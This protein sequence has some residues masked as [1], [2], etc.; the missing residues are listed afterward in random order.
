MGGEATG[1]ASRSLRVVALLPVRNGSLLLPEYLESAAQWCDA[2]IAL[3][4]GSSDRS[5]EMLDEHPLVRLCL[6]MHRRTDYGGWDDQRN[7]QDLLDAANGVGAEWVVYLDVDERI[8]P[9]DALALRGFLTSPDALPGCAYGFQHY[10]MWGR[11][12]D[13]DYCWIYRCFRCEVGQR[14]TSK[15]LHFNPIPTSIDRRAWVRT[16]IRV[17]HFGASSE[18]LRLARLQKYR[19]ADPRHEYGYEFGG[20]ANRPRRIILEWPRRTLGIEVLSDAITRDDH[21]TLNDG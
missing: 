15:R 7:R 1:K 5:G 18:Q 4:D 16:T 20:L 11:G 17:Q 8:D 13:P 19:Q 6:R 14:L 10:R 2:V 12:H 9:H 3:D 21:C